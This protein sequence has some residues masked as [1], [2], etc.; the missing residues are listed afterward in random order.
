[1]TAADQLPEMRRQ[2]VTFDSMVSDPRWQTVLVIFFAVTVMFS[3]IG[4]EGLANYDDCFYAE[5]AKEVLQTGSWMTLHYNG[6]PAFENPPMYIWLVAVAYKIFGI[7]EYAAIFPSALMGVMTV[8]LI[9]FAARRS[10]GQWTGFFAAIILSTTFIFTRY[11]R[12][13]MFDVTL[14][15]FVTA[16]L[17]SLWLALHK[18]ARYF[19]LW[20]CC[21]AVAVLIKSVLGLFPAVISVTF[22]LA[23]GHWKKLFSLTFL[24]GCAIIVLLGFSWYFHELM[25]FGKSFYSLHFGWL[26]IERGFQNAPEPWYAHLSYLKDLLVYYWPWLPLFIYG[27][28]RAVR[29][30]VRR[31]ERSILL[32]LWVLIIVGTMSA[33]SNRVLWYIMPIFPAA[34]IMC[35]E[36]LTDL[37][38]NSARL[39][40]AKVCWLLAIVVAI[41]INA[42]PLQLGMHREVEVRTIAPYVKY[43]GNEGATV[44]G[45]RQPF[46]GLNNAL[47]FYSDHAANPIVSTWNE[48]DEAFKSEKTV[49]CV[50]NCTDLNDLAGHIGNLSIIKQC[51]AL[52]LVANRQLNTSKVPTL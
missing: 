5:K 45:Y 37:L 43:Y 41:L 2:G 34:A 18:D 19:F 49:L 21:T 40:F 10:Y 16:A 50:V 38:S 15:F 27:F 22:L 20:G 51:A 31:D 1:M 11:A 47:L 44:I 6:N 26:I 7:N 36:S 23:T 12:R 8:L 17:I 42:T 13:A 33:M 29:G 32:A 3:K 25:M 28:I 39:R 30:A 4:T 24:G 35:G 14:S 48:V 52:A 46:Y 9:Y